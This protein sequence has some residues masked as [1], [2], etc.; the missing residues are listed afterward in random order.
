MKNVKNSAGS[1]MKQKISELGFAKRRKTKTSHSK[2]QKL[3]TLTGFIPVFP[4]REELRQELQYWS[5]LDPLR[6][7][8]LAVA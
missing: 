2:R 6:L 3:F 1:R 8:D 7:K 4:T 5:D